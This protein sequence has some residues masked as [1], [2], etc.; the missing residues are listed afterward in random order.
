[1][2]PL[3]TNLAASLLYLAASIYLLLLIK[4][5]RSFKQ[6]AAFSLTLGAIILH[7]IGVYQL[8]ALEAG[9]D[10]GIFKMASFI[11]FAI[12]V[13]ILISSLRKPL[14]NLFIFFFPLSI[15]CIALSTTLPQYSHSMQVSHGVAAHI[16]LSIIAYSVLSI[17][18]LQA[19]LWSWQNHQLKKNQLT[20]AVKLLPPL[21]TMELLI[22]ELLWA[23]VIL[24]A[25]GIMAG[26]IYLDNI[27][28]QQLVH[29]TV[30]SLFALMVFAALLWGRHNLGWRGNTAVKWLLSG[31]CLLMLAYFGSKV[32]LELILNQG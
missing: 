24:L 23:G 16:L 6:K 5:Q 25:L 17:A 4:Q 9:I 29:K 3:A 18:T 1:M 22:F 19:I 32:V 14:H 7:G 27:F 30:L 11:V 15:L 10:L 8:M 2:L 20:G 13:L 28:A 21:Q 12:N 26:F 31:F